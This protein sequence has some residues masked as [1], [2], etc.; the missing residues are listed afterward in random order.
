MDITL[1][2]KRRRDSGEGQIKKHFKTPKPQPQQQPQ[3]EKSPSK[4]QVPHQQTHSHPTPPP[5]HPTPSQN[6]PTSPPLAPPEPF[7]PLPILSLLQLHTELSKRPRFSPR[8]GCNAAQQKKLGVE[9]SQSRL[10]KTGNIQE[11]VALCSTD[12]ESISDF[13]LRKALKPLLDLEKI[14]KKKCR[15]LSTLR[16]THGDHLRPIGW[17]PNPGCVEIPGEC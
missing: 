4:E 8:T 11:A 7:H 12:L 9:L 1:N 17:Q 10:L 15:I 6:H 14:R 2:L 13:Q 5:N 16:S 3:Q